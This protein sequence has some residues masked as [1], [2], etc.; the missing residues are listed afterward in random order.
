MCKL[1]FLV[2]IK[3]DK[4]SLGRLFG[5]RGLVL[6]IVNHRDRKSLQLRSKSFFRFCFQLR[7]Q[8]DDIC[9]D[10]LWL[11]WEYI[12]VINKT[13]T[14]WLPFRSFN[15][16]YSPIKQEFHPSV[17]MSVL[18]C[19]KSAI[20]CCCKHLPPRYRQEEYLVP[21][22]RV[23]ILTALQCPRS[24]HNVACSNS[25]FITCRGDRL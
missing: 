4:F 22:C 24:L 19:R 16:F 25:L 8:T 18:H 9:S 14:P 20:I 10:V 13:R 7:T 2:V 11:I 17:N 12:G 5:I 15:F 21:A 23:R 3:G 6:P 1:V